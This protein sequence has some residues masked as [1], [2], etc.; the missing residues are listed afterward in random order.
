MTLTEK[1]I[2]WIGIPIVSI[3]SMF[4][5]EDHESTYGS[6]FWGFIVSLI[7]TSV[8]WNGSVIIFFHWRKKYP[9]IRDTTK[10]LGLTLISLTLFISLGSVLL[11]LIFHPKAFQQLFSIQSYFEGIPF[12][13]AASLLIGMIYETTFYYQQWNESFRQ[14]ERLKNQQIR[15]QFE[16]LQNQMSPHFLFNSLNTLTTLIEESP[17]IAIEFTQN[18]SEVYRYILR[19]KEKELITLSEELEFS[20]SYLSLLKIRYPDNL[21]VRLDIDPA[22]EQLYLPPLTLQMLIENA[23]KHNSV[24]KMKPLLLEIYSTHQDILV[25]KNN[26]Q[27]KTSLER[28][29][30]TGLENIKKRYEL[31]GLPTIEVIQTTQNFMVVL[32]L[33]QVSELLEKQ[34]N[35]QQV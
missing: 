18:L 16:V 30:K 35:Y 22:S 33:I 32:H 26:L 5:V 19:Q 12:S 7:Y 27:P 25:V 20:K 14:N 8:Y 34:L 11:D 6:W 23:I 31:L 9:A 4:V 2:R 28:S 24:S 1:K 15:T 10:K 13:F 17:K 3:L 21:K 29:T